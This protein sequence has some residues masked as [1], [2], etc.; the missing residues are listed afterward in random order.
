M[1]M[2]RISETQR[3]IGFAMS[4]AEDGLNNAIE[5]LVAIRNNRFPNERKP[6]KTRKPSKPIERKADEMV[7]SP[8]D[9]PKPVAR[10]CTNCDWKGKTAFPKPCPKCGATTEAK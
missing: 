8:D 1:R 10:K 4:A 5:S 3:L 7:D 2:K 6:R 9:G